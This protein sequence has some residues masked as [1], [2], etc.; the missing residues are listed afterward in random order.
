MA[1]LILFV[2]SLPAAAAPPVRTIGIVT[3][4]HKSYKDAAAGLQNLLTEKGQRCVVV[5][6]PESLEQASP[7]EADAAPSGKS[8]T[9]AP[10][11]ASA[12]AAPPA[13]PAEQA[14]KA[15]IEERPAAI[16]T[17]GASATTLVL[18]RVPKTP[19]VFCMIPNALDMP[20]LAADSPHSRRVAGVAMDVS[21]GEQIGWIARLCREARHVCVLHSGR[22]KRTAEALQAAARDK[23]LA[24]TLIDARREE[25]PKAVETLSAKG[26]DGVLMLP[27][28]TVYNSANVQRLLLWGIRQKRAVW[29]FSAN[30]VKAGALAGQYPDNQ[31]MLRQTAEL[32][33]KAIEKTPSKPIGLVYPPQVQTAI[34]ERT[35]EMIGVE[36]ESNLLESVTTRFGKAP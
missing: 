33:L 15:L 25:F 22:S 9:T 1:A 5:E 6:L 10:A 31:A 18:D 20:F 7:S 23:G 35:A 2:W 4:A 8:A 28:A 3:G 19:V 36:L 14:L 34:N 30:I 11:T 24:F 21:P 29:A 12:P 32:V 13:D 26:C 27:D 16:V 17:C